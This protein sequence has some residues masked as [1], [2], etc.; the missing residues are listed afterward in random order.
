MHDKPDVKSEKSPE[1]PVPEALARPDEEPERQIEPVDAEQPPR[2]EFP[3]V[4]IGASAGGL[5]AI[6]EFLDAMRPD[7][8]M[9]FV[10]IQHLPP[11]HQSM[12][13]EILSKRT[14]MAVIQVEDGMEIRPDHL[15]VI[16][17]GHT[18]TIKDGALHLGESLQKRGHGHPVDDFFKSLAEEQR[19]RGI[20]IVMSGM[21][22]NGTA[23]C[24]AVKAVGGM[25]IAQ[26]PESAEFPSMPRHLIDSGYAD[27][28]LRPAEI[29]DVLLAYAGHPY[30]REKEAADKAL[31]RDEAH[32][33]EILA[34]L[35][36]RTRQDFSGYKKPTVLRRV[37]RRMGLTRLTRMGY[38]SKIL[39]HNPNEVTALAD[40]LLIHVTGFFRDPFAWEVLRREVIVP[41]VAGKEA[42]SPLRCWVTA[43]SSGEEAYSLAM[44][45][46]EESERIAKPLDIKVFATDM[47]DRSLQ[48]ARAGIYPGGIESEVTPERLTRFFQQ[49]DEVYHIR[50]DLR[51]RVTFAPQNVLQ[52]PPFSRLDIISCRNLLIYLEPSVQQRLLGLL[53]FGLR[54]RGVLFLGTSETISGNQELFEPID[55]RARIYRRI[56]PTR[57][58]EIDFPL[59][60]ILQEG[61]ELR[62]RA[63]PEP[64]T[65]RPSLAQLT[66]RALLEHH[67][68][69]AVLVDHD[70]RIL[71]FHGDT[72]PFLDQPR[73]AATRD[74]LSLAREGVR[75]AVRIALHR[76]AAEHAPATAHE[77]WIESD[78][79]QRSRLS[80]TASP[81]GELGRSDYFVVSFEKGSAFSATP[82]SA[83]ESTSSENGKDL[84]N[85]L[86]RVRAE[87]QSTIEEL[88][89]S[90]E[91]M[92][93][94]NEE[95]M[96]LNEELQSTN[97]EIETSKEEMQSLNE[98]LVTVNSQLEARIIE[99]QKTS[100]DLSS[101]LTSTDIAVLFL[102]QR[103]AI[104]R[105]TPAV[106]G[107]LEVISSDVGRP[108]TDLARKFT[109]PDLIS[110]AQ[111]V[112]ERLVPMDREI[113][114]PDGRW[115]LRRITPYRTIDNRIDGVVVTFFDITQTKKT[116]QALRRSEERFR[117]LIAA[118]SQAIFRLSADLGEMLELRGGGFIQTAQSPTR[119]WLQDYIH[120]DDREM[121]MQAW[122]HALRARD[123][124]QLEHRVRRTDGT[125]GW[126]L[127]RAVPLPDASGQISE[128][129]GA[130]SDITDR[131]RA[132]Q[133]LYD[134]EE[135]I[136]L[137][138]ENIQDYAL[139][140]VD[141]AGMI[142][143]WN[144]GAQRLFGYAPEQIMG[145]SAQVLLSPRTVP[146]NYL[147]QELDETLANGRAERQEWM[148]R[149]D[150]T[151]FWATWITTPIR[152]KDGQ[153]RGFAKILRDLTEQRRV[154]EAMR[155]S[156]ERFRLMVEGARD[157]AIFMLDR[158]GLITAWNTGAQR[159]LGWSEAEIIGQSGKI[160]FTP[161]DRA[162]GGAEME[163]S[164]AITT[165]RATD[166]RWH[167]RK[168]GT[169]FW[170]S[171]VL[172]A[173][174]GSGTEVE[175]FVKVLRDET[176]RKEIELALQTAKSAADEA[177]RLKDQFLA[178]MSHELRTPLSA[179]LLWAGILNGKSPAP[180]ELQEGLAAIITSAEAQ[181][182][183]I[184]DILDTSRITSGTLRMRL[185]DVDL[186]ALVR[187]SAE[188][189]RPNAEGKKLTIATDFSPDTGIVRGDAERLRQ[190]I[191]NLLTNAVKFTPSGGSIHLSTA[192]HG[193]EIEVKV[194]DTGEGIRPE[195]L[196]LIFQPFKQ[197][198]ASTTR[199]QGGLGL[200][201]AITQQLVELHGGTISVQS[202]GPGKGTTFT[203]RLPNAAPTPQGT[204]PEPEKRGRRLPT[205]SPESLAGAHVLLV[206][207]DPDMRNAVIRILG[208]AGVEV[209]AVGS[210]A[211]ALEAYE[212]KRPHLVLSDIGLPETDGYAL[213]RQLR[214]REAAAGMTPV[215]AV[216]VTAFARHE[217]RQR[218]MESGFQQYLSK[219]VEPDELLTT[220]GMLL[221]SRNG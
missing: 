3:V 52:D 133:E 15:Y 63:R 81:A 172:H 65:P 146:D 181:K 55:K 61:S 38:Y 188:A 122:R 136:S 214:L 164:Q 100:N 107:L 102:D 121:V 59:P 36:I 56:G 23:G 175:G 142:T 154:E 9:A 182:E 217:D 106:K 134:A 111:L 108:L 118:S 200:G 37:Q 18:L 99:H 145:R 10:L 103:L 74:L 132:E 218:A 114:G 47:A 191:W 45:L 41:L 54:E 17:P 62:R 101:L 76:A 73:G 57:H 115:F 162:A 184:D 83:R 220:L 60:R 129:F 209:T 193:D 152:D 25:C 42:N 216:A 174:R 158:G 125:W 68:P 6:S 137:L 30:A 75:G 221:K 194:S 5:E 156:E 58:G 196:S 70:Y 210:A 141:P 153:L 105:F 173:V 95:A 161:E 14:G 213:L 138:V 26:D 49:E 40:D 89:T 203:V 39:R 177:N 151:S 163:I 206:E 11:D 94:S 80:V 90:N 149:R 168:N 116:A 128:W 79:G 185:R 33:R 88:Q 51:E 96:S 187:E 104:R 135:R 27:Y 112:L 183:L 91:E 190:V 198:D 157:F 208:L 72:N 20:S 29:P 131:K 166:E 126:A 7:N 169:R 140:Q 8:G 123:M 150:G 71:Y 192:R 46:L 67:T 167:V 19:E 4:G 2:L 1:Q 53:H 82:D 109:D 12:M 204:F 127:S 170:A 202:P 77:G 32:L 31:K 199:R 171:G 87:L 120:P 85:E 186:A 28:I 212:H 178:T 219:P 86:Q 92:K 34:L 48:N 189:I 64:V 180:D 119:T 195:F 197:A 211:A 124:F 22:S 16:R 117:A 44:L 130:A 155:E 147:R 215:P 201:L 113:A 176:A 84:A 21:G 43:C 98:E 97:E 144:N 207:D 165:G 69:P 78:Q 13:A 143:S 148:V 24:Q 110:E 160:I 50:Q 93:A 139:F 205:P 159:L 179:I 35:R 66:Q